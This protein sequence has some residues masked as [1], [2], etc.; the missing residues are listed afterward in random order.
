MDC[1]AS[2]RGSSR[3]GQLFFRIGHLLEDYVRYWAWLVSASKGA[4]KARLESVIDPVFPDIA[5]FDYLVDLIAQIGPHDI[6][7]TDLK[8]WQDITGMTLSKWEADSIRRLSILFTNKFQEYNDKNITS[9]YRDVDA[10][11]VD[12][13][14]IQSML[15]NDQR[16]KNG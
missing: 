12:Q 8:A 10:P 6:S 13:K 9:P 7:W 14:T 1:R 15:R 11:T 4:K 2:I 5:P 16:F 3:S